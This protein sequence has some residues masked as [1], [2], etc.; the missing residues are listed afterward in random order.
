MR[1]LK[2]LEF[3]THHTWTRLRIMLFGDL[4]TQFGH[5][6]IRLLLDGRTNRGGAPPQGSRVTT[7]MGQRGHAPG[8]PPASPPRRNGG[9]AHAKCLGNF[10]LGLHALL[11]RRD[12]TFSEV[13]R[14]S[15]HV[16]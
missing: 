5:S 4:L 8:R 1:A 10:G 6:D 16:R 2:P 15:F 12:D 7:P 3:T 13:L 14:V 11:D 9:L